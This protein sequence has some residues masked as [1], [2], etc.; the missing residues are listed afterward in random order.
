[1]HEYTVHVQYLYRISRQSNDHNYEYM[2]FSNDRP[3]RPIISIRT[4]E[5]SYV[6]YNDSYTS[7]IY[8][9]WPK[10]IDGLAEHVV[11]RVS[12]RLSAQSGQT[13]KPFDASKADLLRSQLRACIS[14]EHPVHAL[15]SKP[16]FT[17][18]SLCV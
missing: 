4:Y 17:L 6:E 14:A 3:T 11:V 8:R 1:M 16:I 9:D 5:Y 7:K 12:A 2:Y 18:L 15:L 10:E 13:S